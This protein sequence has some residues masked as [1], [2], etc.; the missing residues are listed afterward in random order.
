[1]TAKLRSAAA[2][3][4]EKSPWLLAGPSSTTADGTL[5]LDL[6]EP[7]AILDTIL[8]VADETRPILT[9]FSAAVSHAE[10]GRRGEPGDALHGAVMASEGAVTLA[11]QGAQDT[12]P[13]ERRV[14]V[15]LGEPDRLIASLIELVLIA[16]DR[17]TARQRQILTLVRSSDTQQQV[18]S[19]LGVSRQAVNQTLAAA[20]W[21]QLARAERAIIE[22]LSREEPAGSTST[23]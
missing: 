19:H 10:T 23:R 11:L 16:Y 1:M 8:L 14:V 5:L 15:R 21:R 17:M 13:K 20:A 3:I 6:S 2:R 7:A 18:A 9:T 12:D 4:G 22:R